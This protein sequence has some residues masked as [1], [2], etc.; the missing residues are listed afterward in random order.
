MLSHELD[1]QISKINRI[2][3][4]NLP[5]PLHECAALA[6][7]LN[8]KELFIKREDLTG[9]AFGGNKVRHLEFR[10]G[11]IKKNNFDIIINANMGV[12]NNARLWA[13]AANLNNVKLVNI[14]SKELKTEMQG[15]H[16]LNHLMNVEIIYSDTRN[17]QI[18]HQE[19]IE[20]GNKLKQQG[21][22]PY[23]TV[24]EQYNEIAAVISYLNTALELNKQFKKLGL[25]KIHIF[26]ASGSSYLG[27]ALAKKILNLTHWKITGI[28]PRLQPRMRNIKGITNKALNYLNKKSGNKFT[29]DF[30]D[31]KDLN[32]DLSFYGQGYGIQTKKSIA[33]IKLLAE[34]EAIFLDPIYTGKA[35]SG[36]IEYANSNKIDKDSSVVFIHSGG[37]PNLFTYSNELLA[38][39]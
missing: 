36:L 19:A 23:I 22:K 39:N 24:A 3:F 38:T 16:F 12:S 17:E 5:T 20:Y 9:L 33:A 31:Y 2:K 1:K 7:E 4:A 21:Y 32:W 25:K 26:Q 27:L 15:N 10:L 29:L 11:Y 37:T 35:M 34:K 13:A 18:L 14:M 30:L 28:G 8:I 6:K